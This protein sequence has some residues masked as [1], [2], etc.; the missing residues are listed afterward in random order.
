MNVAR[1]IM[2]GLSR[3]A[4]V[5]VMAL[6][7]ACG[8]GGGDTPPPPASAASVTLTVAT[9]G[10]GT[11]TVTSNPAG[12]N[13]GATCTLTVPSMNNIFAETTMSIIQRQ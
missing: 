7:A 6:L 4:V 10:G 13:C 11:G 9:A 5:A 3:L 2:S 1:N 12:L 8:T